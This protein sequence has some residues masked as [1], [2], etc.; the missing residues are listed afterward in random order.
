VWTILALVVAAFFTSTLTAVVGMGG[1]LLLVAIMPGLV[2]PEAVV[3]LHGVVQ[4]ASNG[5]RV[6][7]GW[8]AVAWRVVWPFVLG[9]G[10]GAASGAPLL[11][12]VPTQYVPMVLGA[13]VLLV[14]WVPLRIAA[15]D[16]RG[17]WTMVG[18]VASALALFVGAAGPLTQP[19]LMQEQLPRDRL[20]VTGGAL[21]A[22]NHIA[23]IVVYGALGF[24]FGPYL[25]LGLAMIAAVTAGSWVGTRLRGRLPE[26][27]FRLLLRLLLTVLALRSIAHGA[28]WLS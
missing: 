22:I 25:A 1:G 9:A 17:K 4:L 11:A 20:V 8:H 23:K 5:T 7:F 10:I 28:G 18:A 15:R 27:R 6:A 21:S 2:A 16:F 3:P 13:F 12:R 14:T 19:V 24:S 26:A